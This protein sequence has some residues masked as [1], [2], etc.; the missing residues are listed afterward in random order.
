MFTNRLIIFFL[1]LACDVITPH[2]VLAQYHFQ[3]SGTVTDD[4]T[5]ESLAGTSVSVKGKSAGTTSDKNGKFNLTFENDSPEKIILLFRFT[6]YKNKEVPVAAGTISLSI[7]LQR[8]TIFGSEVQITE[9]RMPQYILESPVT[10]VK[11]DAKAIKEIPNENFYAGLASVKGIDVSTNSLFYQSINMRGPSNPTSEGVLQL[12]DGMD[13][14]PP[15]QGFSVGNLAGENDL[16]IESVEIIPGSSSS[17]YGANAFSGLINI[18]TKSPFKYQGLSVDFKNG[19]T[20]IDGKYHSPTLFSD[21][22]VRYA[23]AWKEKFAVKF[24]FGY[25]RGTDWLNLDQTDWDINTSPENRGI[26]NP[27]RDLFNIYGDEVQQ[28]LTLGPDNNDVNVS[29][30]GY[31]ANDVLGTSTNSLKVHPSIHYK[32]NKNTELSYLFSYNLFNTNV[33]PWPW[34]FRHFSVTYH[35]LEMKRKNFFIR[36]YTLNDYDG[37]SYDAISSSQ[38]IN[39]KWKS[40]SA[41]FSDYQNAYNGNL[42]GVNSNNHSVARNYADTGR[43]LPGSELYNKLLAETIDKPLNLQDGSRFED[44]SNLQHVHAQ[45]D[46]SEK[47]HW[48]KII[49]GAEARSRNLWSDGTEFLDYPPAHYINTKNYGIYVQCSKDFLHDKLNIL[50]SAR[51]DKYDVFIGNLTPRLAAVYKLNEENFFRASFQTGAR[52]PDPFDLYRDSRSGNFIQAG[53]APLSD[54]KYN[55]HAR[56]IE[57]QSY[58]DFLDKAY[59]YTDQYGDDSTDAAIR[60]Y[61]N[62]L[63]PAP[64]DYVHA[65]KVQT[66]EVGYQCLMFHKKLHLDVDF[67]GSI[68]KDLI[69]YQWVAIAGT[70]NPFGDDSLTAAAFAFLSGDSYGFSVPVNAKDPVRSGGVEAGIE[71]NFWKDYKVAANFIYQKTSKRDPKIDSWLFQIAPIKTNLSISNPK[72]Y[73]NFGFAINWHWTDAAGNFWSSL[74]PAIGENKIHANSILDGQITL[75]LPHLKSSIKFGASNLLNHYYQNQAFG[76]SV[77]GVYYISILYGVE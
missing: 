52:T 76:A 51:Y 31:N 36:I 72:C 15:G 19:L 61:K 14:T 75:A 56:A 22:Q 35:K 64:L 77:G 33:L 18:T 28:T 48:M 4:A 50:V 30:T 63:Q 13:N 44:R 62:I 34:N 58:F 5:S 7:R 39:N 29:R 8:D 12:V 17:I 32:I 27:G 57:L 45:Y 40:D 60:L 43:P 65:E 2:H 37:H 9:S 16:D 42:S 59:T 1:F 3:V 25:Q 26:E 6:G 38:Y 41:W 49:T 54:E 53:G 46:F 68:Y 24:N 74:N 47:F 11:L 73:K 21:Y 71:Y 23:K 55:L 67:F 66:L 20:N 69:A 10:I 70:G